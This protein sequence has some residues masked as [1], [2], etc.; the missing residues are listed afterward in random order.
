MSV[1]VEAVV[2]DVG[3]VLVEW[4]PERFYDGRYGEAR[5]RALFEAVDLHAMNERIDRGEEF[6]RIVEETA[7]ANPAFAAEIGDWHDAWIEMAQP[8]IPHSVGLLRA[9]RS[10][11]VPVHALTNFGRET[12]AFALTQYP[13]LDEF[14]H[15]FVSGHLGVTKPDPAI[16]A[17]V[18]ERTGLAPGTILF[19]DDREENVAAARDRGWGTHLF[20]GPEGWAARLV[21]EGLLSEAEAAPG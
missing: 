16:Y 6:R 9:L 11:G 21:E 4:N 8:P 19:A 14:D 1:Q 15:A 2:F 3:N 18:E 10:K 20:D 7:A 17:A 13:F 12:F 5:R